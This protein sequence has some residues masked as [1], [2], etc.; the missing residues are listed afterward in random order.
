MLS[1]HL[2]L[3]CDDD[4]DDDDDVDVDEVVFVP[5]AAAATA[6][7]PEDKTL[8]NDEVRDKV[9]VCEC[10]DEVATAADVVVEVEDDGKKSLFNKAIVQT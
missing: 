1:P 4:D 7:P 3:R 5:A 9:F 2:A 10:A 8:P 6:R